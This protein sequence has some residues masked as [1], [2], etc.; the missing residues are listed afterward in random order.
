MVQSNHLLISW[1]LLNQSPISW[2]GEWFT[3]YSSTIYQSY[4]YIG[5]WTNYASTKVMNSLRVMV[6]PTIY[7]DF[8]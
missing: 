8:Q 4:K 1:L 5:E 7:R 6:K 3:N 2:I